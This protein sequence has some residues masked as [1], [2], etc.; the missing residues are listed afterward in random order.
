M[1]KSKTFDRYVI[2]R[3]RNAKA[4]TGHGHDCKAGNLKRGFGDYK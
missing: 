1:T 2:C 3:N 4:L